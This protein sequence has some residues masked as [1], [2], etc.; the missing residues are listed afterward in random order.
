MI[1]LNSSAHNEVNINC[2]CHPGFATSRKFS[3]KK[4]ITLD[5]ELDSPRNCSNAEKHA[6]LR[7]SGCAPI[8]D[9]GGDSKGKGQEVKGILWEKNKGW[10]GLCGKDLYLAILWSLP[11]KCHTSQF[12][13]P[14]RMP[15]LLGEDI[16]K[17]LVQKNF[18]AFVQYQALSKREPKRIIKVELNCNSAR[19]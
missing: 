17:P 3:D 4:I 14:H 16:N 15:L 18:E 6:T 9:C 5:I 10:S 11:Q 7:S 8:A 13:L 12:S 2:L 19:S 1:R